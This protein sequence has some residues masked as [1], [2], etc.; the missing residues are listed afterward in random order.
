M[1]LRCVP[2]QR[3]TNSICAALG[4]LNLCT[5]PCARDAESECVPIRTVLDFF[6]E[7]TCDAQR[8]WAQCSFPCRIDPGDEV[9]HAPPG[10]WL[11][12]VPTIAGGGGGDTDKSVEI[13]VARDCARNSTVLRKPSEANSYL[14][15][16]GV[17]LAKESMW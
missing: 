7:Q 12:S 5:L 17:V 10:G 6:V 15:D 9:E 4:A 16:H 11:V 1:P 8:A 13:V 3:I 2:D 14:N